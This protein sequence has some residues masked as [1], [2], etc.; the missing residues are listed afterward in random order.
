MRAP[1]S[2]CLRSYINQ[3]LEIPKTQDYQHTF[4]QWQAGDTVLHA[5]QTL[6]TPLYTC[7]TAGATRANHVF[8]L[9]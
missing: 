6:E 9:L 2:V 3:R 4:C 1:K 8:T 5:S 7:E